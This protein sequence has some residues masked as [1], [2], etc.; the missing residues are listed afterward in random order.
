MANLALQQGSDEWLAFRK[1][2]IGASDLPAI[3]G[4]S[5]WTTPYQ[6]WQMKTGRIPE[7]QMTQ[8]MQR[9][10]DLEPEARRLAES[11]FKT[12]LEPLVRVHA[13]EWAIAS[14]DA[15]S[16]DGDLIVEIKCPSE[17]YHL[18]TIETKS[19][20]KH[21][22]CQCQWQMY[23]TGLQLMYYMSYSEDS[24]EILEVKRN[25]VL[26]QEM[27]EKA[28]DFLQCILTDTPPEVSANDSLY[29]ETEGNEELKT[30]ARHVQAQYEHFKDELAKVKEEI[31][32]LTDGGKCES[33]FFKV[34]QQVR[35]TI[36]YD[37]MI[38]DLKIDPLTVELYK[39]PPT[40]STV[41]KIL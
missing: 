41:V 10:H 27:E 8:A 21:Y 17:K 37:K 13:N 11:H 36:D 16:I 39:K 18:E 40:V 30:R 15:V 5:P 29:I 33:D 4:V 12:P 14:L 22:E 25:D 3:M 32:D 9:G 23:V 7:K 38:K 28:Y 20:P 35:Q 2:K 6:L 24:Y 26:I 31:K 1:N 34:W 19:V